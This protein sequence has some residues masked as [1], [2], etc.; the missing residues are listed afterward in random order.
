MDAFAHCLEAYCAPTY[1]PMSAGIA[2][3]GMQL[4]KDN[5]AKAVWNRANIAARGNMMSAA[6]MGAVSFQKGLGAIHSLSHPVGSLYH[7][8]H[9]L[10]NGTFMPYV[11]AFNRS[12]R[13]QDRTAGPGARHCRRL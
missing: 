8:H 7:T 2:V 13:G 3:E 1:H 4:V 5:L 9:G 11:L 6:A 10:T 12:D